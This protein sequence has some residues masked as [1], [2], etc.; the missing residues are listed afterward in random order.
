MCRN[1]LLLP[2]FILS[3]TPLWADDVTA[4]MRKEILNV[5]HI[6]GVAASLDAK[7]ATKWKYAA[8]S[9]SFKSYT[10]TNSEQISFKRTKDST[11]L[12]DLSVVA[13]EQLTST[14][15]S[16]I[17]GPSGKNARYELLSAVN[18][19]SHPAQQAFSSIALIDQQTAATI[20]FTPNETRLL[21]I[22]IGNPSMQ[23]TA[24]I[25][26]PV[27]N[28]FK[29]NSAPFDS[30]DW[31]YI[32]R[33]DNSIVIPINEGKATVCKNGQLHWRNAKKTK[34]GLWIVHPVK[35]EDKLWTI[36]PGNIDVYYFSNTELTYHPKILT[37]HPDDEGNIWMNFDKGIIGCLPKATSK[38]SD[39]TYE[40][41][42]ALYNFN[43]DAGRYI[44]TQ[45]QYKQLIYQKLKGMVDEE[46]ADTTRLYRNYYEHPEAYSHQYLENARY[47]LYSNL[48]KEKE[49][50][51]D[52]GQ[53]Y[54]N[55]DDLWK[56]VSL[57]M[58][59]P[60][61]KSKHKLLRYFDYKVR[62]FQTLHN[63]IT[64]ADHNSVLAV[65]N[66]SLYKVHYNRATSSITTDWA[67]PY[68]NSFLKTA[69]WSAA[70]SQTTPAYIAERNEVVF[71]DNAFP[72]V[73]LLILDAAK[74][75]LKYQFR[76]FEQAYGSAVNN[77][78]SCNNNTMLAGNT[79]GNPIK[80]YDASG[81]YPAKG[82]Q[83]FSCTA[84]GIWQKDYDWSQLQ[85]GTTAGAAAIK[86]SDANDKAYLYHPAENAEWQVSAIRND[87]ADRSAPIQFSLQPDFK[88]IG[89]I[90][91]QHT[92]GNFTFGP[93]Q[94]LMIGTAAGLLRVVTE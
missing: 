94:S 33:T 24:S 50:T 10:A 81:T 92:T 23:V 69:G 78:V 76:L 55:P 82:I 40:D 34:P 54:E 41:K 17:K 60:T 77:A 25:A 64:S 3:L 43:L 29:G 87:K 6:S 5:R 79:F 52:S 58:D 15:T 26:V 72:Q 63:S 4:K 48:L 22:D 88:N 8:N 91:L 30:K 66:C 28:P 65:T 14:N 84:S 83:K 90:F 70:T 62:L 13:F 47:T 11:L 68:E 46:N 37:A 38:T 86:R 9:S 73:N 49:S 7:Q 32:N 20:L 80:P 56:Y 19:K 31:F 35:N 1:L 67:T 89:K 61:T 75:T 42:V 36:S 45:A 2:V 12:I 85:Q 27:A 93:H 53:V 71:C 44:N 51:L 57:E 21:L 39:A 16:T 74:G 59:A 18:R